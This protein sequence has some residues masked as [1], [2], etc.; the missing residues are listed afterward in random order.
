MDE[1]SDDEQMQAIHAMQA[2]L[3]SLSEAMNKVNGDID[4]TMILLEKVTERTENFREY[5]FSRKM[6]DDQRRQILSVT[7]DMNIGDPESVFVLLLDVIDRLGA[8][9]EVA[10]KEVERLDQ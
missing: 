7:S 2:R 10:K 6:I 1:M 8:L 4:M 3:V 5:F 9:L